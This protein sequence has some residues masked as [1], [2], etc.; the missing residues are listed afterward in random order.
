MKLS[1]DRIL[2]THSGALPAPAAIKNL[3]TARHGGDASANLSDEDEITG[4][5]SDSIQAQIDLGIDVARFAA[6][7]A[8]TV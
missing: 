1:T 2:T 8:A 3:A 6:G 5:I 4:G 7:L